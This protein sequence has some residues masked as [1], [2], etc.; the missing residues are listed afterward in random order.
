MFVFGSLQRKHTAL[1]NC[2]SNII[3][4]VLKKNNIHDGVS[5]LINGDRSVGEW[6]TKDPRI[7]LI[8]ATGSTN[9]GRSVGQE[10]A[11]RF[12]K[13]ILELGGNNALIITPDADIKISVVG[14]V[15][16]AVG[17]AGQGAQQLG[18]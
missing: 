4:S 8:S 10:V 16:G 6:L 12:G 11:K 17:T 3:A 7:A 9:M 1:W 5:C 14:A 15:F 2:L 18:D 13:T